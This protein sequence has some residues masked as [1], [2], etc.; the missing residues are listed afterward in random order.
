M[1]EL[2]AKVLAA[3]MNAAG[4]DKRA[5]WVRDH[6]QIDGVSK[7]NRKK[8][9]TL[10]FDD[11][12]LCEGVRFAGAGGGISAAAV[13]ISAIAV[14]DP[15][16]ARKLIDGFECEAERAELLFC[17]FGGDDAALDRTSQFPAPRV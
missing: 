3:V 10:Y 13:T 12:D 7:H 17:A 1:N 11:A 9:W 5:M 2:Q 14:V 4:D 8:Q 15:D 6:I 16:A